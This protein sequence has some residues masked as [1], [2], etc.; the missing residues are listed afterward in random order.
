MPGGAI[1]GASDAHAAYPARYPV[2]P[3]DIAAIVYRARGIDPATMIRDP[4]D[5][6]HLVSTGTPIAAL[7][8]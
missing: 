1:F 7:L 6:P 8:A 4:L 3:P 2:T 5:R